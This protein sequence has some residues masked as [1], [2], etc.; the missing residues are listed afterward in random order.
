MPWFYIQNGQRR[1]P[2]EEAELFRL[3]REGHLA[4]DDLVWNPSMGEQWMPASSVPNLFALPATPSP[5]VPGATPNGDLMRQAIASLRNR[6]TLAVGVGLL[7][8]V[9]TS[10]IQFIPYLGPILVLV[11]Y[12]PMLLGFNR[13]FLMIARNQTPD[14]GQLFDGFKLFGKTLGAYVL[15]CLFIFLWMLPLIVAGIF[16]GIAVPLIASNSDLGFLLVPVFILLVISGVLLLVRAALAYAQTFFIL[17]DQPAL[18]AYD[19]IQL[20][21]RMMVGYKWKL[22]CLGLR[23]IGWVLLGFLTCGI[24]LLW[25]QPY[26][27]VANAH[28]YDDIR[29]GT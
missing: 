22:F 1:G 2:V 27:A 19:A 10:G 28:F 24:G 21:I 7:Y 13:F 6:W 29:N 8:Q 18:G 5:G 20:S 25:V 14:V 17:S 15:I 3:A 9:V 11:I 12:G 4:S 23:F 16:A 26:L